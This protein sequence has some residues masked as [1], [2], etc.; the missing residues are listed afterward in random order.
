MKKSK[1]KPRRLSVKK[2]TVKTGR[3]GGKVRKEPPIYRME[4]RKRR[5]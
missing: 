4:P 5:S 2:Q 3:G 1:G